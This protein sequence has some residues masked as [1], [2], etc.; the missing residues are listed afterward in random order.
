MG[1]IQVAYATPVTY[2][3]EVDVMSGDPCEFTYSDRVQ[4]TLTVVVT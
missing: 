1:G 3:V 4:L 2:Q